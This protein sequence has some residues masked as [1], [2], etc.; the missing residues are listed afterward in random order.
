MDWGGNL[1]E[2][3]QA[4]GKNENFRT[5]EEPNNTIGKKGE[6]KRPSEL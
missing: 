6:E 5:V 4:S 3:Y 1:S 2:F